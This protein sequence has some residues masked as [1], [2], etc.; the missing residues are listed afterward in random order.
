MHCHIH[1]S[2][3]V[4][5]LRVRSMSNIY[6]YVSTNNLLVIDNLHQARR[7]ANKQDKAA[8]QMRQNARWIVVNHEISINADIPSVSHKYAHC[9]LYFVLIW[10][11]HQFLMNA[12]THIFRVYFIDYKTHV[13]S[14]SQIA[15]FMGPTW[16]PPG[17]CRPQMG[18]MLAPRTLLFGIIGH[19]K[20]HLT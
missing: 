18:P 14:I 10:L 4:Y 7:Q 9:V 12:Y 11:C 8:L 17:S 3:W 13:R 16:G 20:C 15:K 5:H 2:L 1:T 6:L 19:N